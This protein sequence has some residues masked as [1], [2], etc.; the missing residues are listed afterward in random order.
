MLISKGL[1][2]HSKDNNAKSNK[3][4]GCTNDFGSGFMRFQSLTTDGKI[5]LCQICNKSL[6]PP[7]FATLEG[8]M[9]VGFP[10]FFV[11][12]HYSNFSADKAKDKFEISFFFYLFLLRC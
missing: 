5:V 6:A 1:H 7:C 12:R 10:A 2:V 3:L 8:S 11:P 4:Q 9:D